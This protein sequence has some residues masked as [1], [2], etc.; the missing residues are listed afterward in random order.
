MNSNGN[1]IA[2]GVCENASRAQPYYI[3][4]VQKRSAPSTTLSAIGTFGLRSTGGASTICTS[5]SFGSASTTYVTGEFNIGSSA[6]TSGG[7]A[8]LVNHDGNAK[9]EWSSEL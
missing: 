2:L 4:K 7:A 6:V 1:F 8:W 9:I 3:F 5:G